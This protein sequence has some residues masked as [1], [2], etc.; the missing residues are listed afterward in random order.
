MREQESNSR[1]YARQM[2]GDLTNAEA[3]LWAHLRKGQLDGWHV[4]RQHPIG[5]FITDFA[6]AKARLVIEIDGATHGSDR[7]EADAKRT[8]FLESQGWRVL[9]VWNT[10]I[11]DNLDGV[12]Q[13]IRAE[14]SPLRP[15]TAAARGPG[16]L[17]RERRRKTVLNGS[18]ST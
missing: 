7:I 2:R 16:H 9:R 5:P 3:I 17:P 1:Q 12:M 6:C 11:Y 8:A 14:L 15:E 13:A 18:I 4:R 10:D